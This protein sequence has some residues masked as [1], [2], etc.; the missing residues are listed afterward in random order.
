MIHLILLYYYVIHLMYCI[1]ALM[2][3]T[4][5]L[6]YYNNTSLMIFP[7]VFQP[8]AIHLIPLFSSRPY[9][10]K[11][12]HK[13]VTTIAIRCST[14]VPRE[15]KFP[16]GRTNASRVWLTR[17]EDR[18]RLSSSFRRAASVQQRPESTSTYP[19]CL[20]VAGRTIT[21]NRS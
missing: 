17:V 7:N 2:Y 9:N 21:A 13:Y 3:Y 4:T 18:K 12:R 14:A 11:S 15:L 10:L 6:I 5:I 16:R 19:E 1:N 8:A 20:G